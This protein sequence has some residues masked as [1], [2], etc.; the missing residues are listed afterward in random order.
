MER[1]R[2]REA[3]L[4]DLRAA[5]EAGDEDPFMPLDIEQIIRKAEEGR[6]ASKNTGQSR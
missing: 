5:I 2:V 4:R 6:A 1:E 3:R